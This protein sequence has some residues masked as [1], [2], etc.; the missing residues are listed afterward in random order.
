MAITGRFNFRRTL[1]GKLVLQVEA[2][3]PGWWPFGKTSSPGHVWRDATMADLAAIELQPLLNLRGNP[4]YTPRSPV[5]FMMH[6]DKPAT[7]P[8]AE[9]VTLASH[10][11]ASQG[12]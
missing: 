7:P 3:R 1:T 9:V 10:R 11:A 6:P 12:S 8:S 5:I 4:G 2:V